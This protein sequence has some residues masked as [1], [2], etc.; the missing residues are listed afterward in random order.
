MRW[1]RP[2]GCELMVVPE[3]IRNLT[4]VRELPFN[5]NSL[6]SARFFLPDL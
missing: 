1:K 6:F 4:P 2:A 3:F 5:D